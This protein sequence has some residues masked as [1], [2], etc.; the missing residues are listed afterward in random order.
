MMSIPGLRPI[1][2]LDLTAPVWKV[3]RELSEVSKKVTCDENCLPQIEFPSGGAFQALLMS[4]QL[5]GALRGGPRGGEKCWTSSRR[6]VA[7]RG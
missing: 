7:V 5:S 1:S 3:A 2:Q 6:L 4:R